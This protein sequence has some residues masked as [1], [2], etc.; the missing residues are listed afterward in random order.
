[1]SKLPKRPFVKYRN[2]YEYYF[3]FVFKKIINLFFDDNERMFLNE[4][5]QNNLNKS[6]KI[7][8]KE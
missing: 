3:N 4:N 7:K 8:K 1:M 2:K 6:I 5:I